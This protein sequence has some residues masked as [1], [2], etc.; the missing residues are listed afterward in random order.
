MTH[1]G[2]RYTIEW[3]TP[4]SDPPGGLPRI[5]AEMFETCEQ[6][7]ARMTGGEPSIP[8]W[9]SDL[10][11]IGDHYCVTCQAICTPPKVLP[12][13]SLAV[14]RQKR[15]KRRIEKKYPLFAQEFV[16]QEIERKPEYYAGVTRP[17]LAAAHQGVLDSDQEL[18]Q[19]FLA[20]VSQGD[21]K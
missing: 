9:F 10:C 7:Q 17:D 14:V 2:F 16:G 20:Y 3:F 18:Y 6:R 8:Q 19:R 11:V 12:E 13:S 15:L 4:Y 21:I 5:K 1:V